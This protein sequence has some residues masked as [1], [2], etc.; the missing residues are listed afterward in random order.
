M[1]EQSVALSGASD[2][3]YSHKT[4]QFRTQRLLKSH[5]YAENRKHLPKKYNLIYIEKAMDSQP[6]HELHVIFLPYPTPGHMN[7]M[8]D[9]A[10][11]F[12][13]H[14]VSVTIITTPANALPFQD[15][16][17]GYHIRTQLV[18]FPAAEVGLPE[19]V[20]NIKDSTSLELFFRIDSGILDKN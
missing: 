5:P 4:G 17:R 20:E 11:L 7:P 18:T 15:F 1:E 12:A 2:S 6:H 8:I 10:R 3:K 13:R 16:T 14:G 19:G 9:T